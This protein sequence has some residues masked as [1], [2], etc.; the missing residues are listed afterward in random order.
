[1]YEN[2]L[3]FSNTPTLH[4]KKGELSADLSWTSV[5]AFSIIDQERISLDAGR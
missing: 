2:R 5:Q 1:M 3:S 4:A